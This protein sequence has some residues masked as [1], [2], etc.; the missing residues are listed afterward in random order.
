MENTHT[1]TPPTAKCDLFWV[2]KAGSIFDNQPRKPITSENK[3][4]G[5]NHMTLLTDAEKAADKFN[6]QDKNSQYTRNRELSQTLTSNYK[7]PPSGDIML[8][9]ERL[10]FFP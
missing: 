6:S 7:K 5:K 8:N 10:N 3:E 9:G 2:C 4:G 1:H